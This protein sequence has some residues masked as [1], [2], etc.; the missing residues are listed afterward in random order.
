MKT[1]TYKGFKIIEYVKTK[2]VIFKDKTI[3]INCYG[4]KIEYPN[5]KK[6]VMI[7]HL[8]I[9]LLMNLNI[10]YMRNIK[11]L[12]K[13]K[14]DKFYKENK[15]EFEVWKMITNKTIII[16]SIK[17]DREQIKELVEKEFKIKIDRFQLSHTGL[18]GVLK[19][20]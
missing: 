11:D 20:I 14:I 16:K 10:Y 18:S 15:K 17:L 12:V 19:W 9:N 2:K 3:L 8:Y 7:N 5:Y 6:N 4:V 1:Y 13:E